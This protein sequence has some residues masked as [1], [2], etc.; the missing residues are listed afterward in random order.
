MTTFSGP[1]AVNVFGMTVLASGLRMYAK[2]GMIPNR[3]YTPTKMLRAAETY[4]GKKF[5]RGQYLEAAD[6]LTELARA[7]AANLPQGN[8]ITA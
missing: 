5:K 2:C 4:T 1:A 8:A 3:G 6:A 7:S